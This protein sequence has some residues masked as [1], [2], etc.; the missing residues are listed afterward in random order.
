[1]GESVGVAG[2][3]T[4]GGAMAANIARAGFELRVWNRTAGRTAALE[5]LGAHVA[6]D[7]ASL[8]ASSD[9]VLVCVSDTPDVEQVLFG[10]R[11][12][13]AGIRPGALVIDC[14]SISPSATRQFAARLAATG[15]AY[16]DAPVSGGSEGARNATL[17]IFCGGS[18]ADV[19]RAEP[20]LR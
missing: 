4:M 15:A 17:T 20:V 9:I 6:P 3:G 18:E 13:A 12:V 1:M 8:A 19:R 11:G 7:P 14:S 16:V 2:L 10:E 5:A